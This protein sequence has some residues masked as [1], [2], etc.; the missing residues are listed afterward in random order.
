[1][2]SVI[3]PIQVTVARQGVLL[4]RGDPRHIRLSVEMATSYKAPRFGLVP[5]GELLT[6]EITYGTSERTS[7]E[8]VGLPVLR[9]NNLTM[10]G[11]DITDLKYLEHTDAPADLLLSDGDLLVNRS[12]SLSQV[13]KAAVFDLTGEWVFASF[14]LRLRVD[15]SRVLPDFL[16]QFLNSPSGRL[17]AERL[18]RPILGMANISPTELRSI[19]VPLPDLAEQ[20]L[21]LAPLRA[22]LDAKRDKRRQAVE[23]LVGINA[24]IAALVGALPDSPAS[25]TFATTVA[26][27]RAAGRMGAQ[28]FHP[29]RAAALNALRAMPGVSAKRL[30]AVADLTDDRTGSDNGVPALGLAAIEQGTGQVVGSTDDPAGGRR[31]EAGDVLVSR[32]RPRLNKV[33]VMT[34]SG[35]CSPEFFVL[36]PKPGILPDYLAAV[37]RSPLVMRQFV[38]MNTGNTHPRV[39]E[40]D[41]RTVLIPV[42][43]MSVQQ[44]LA[45]SM[46]ARSTD[47]A[48][49]RTEA[50]TDWAN[51]SAAFGSSLLSWDAAGR[52]LGD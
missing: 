8:G 16:A 37:M 39:A 26:G 35:R 40:E 36:R 46:S 24:E 48:R 38:H 10:D 5:I 14:L 19:L 32:L 3:A 6:E 51:A 47:A 52:A 44:Q 25:P 49:L 42:A 18:A 11:W 4:R 45:A 9:M 34:R 33:A 30:D 12:N 21:L 20:A 17:Q 2:S 1:M 31:F 13:G 23:R 50:E 41:M 7:A 22:A 27:L 28:F 29:E 15:V 43:D